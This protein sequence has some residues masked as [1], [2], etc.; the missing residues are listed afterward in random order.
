MTEFLPAGEQRQCGSESG[1]GRNRAGPGNPPIPRGEWSQPGFLQP[2]ERL[3]RGDPPLLVRM[4][5]ALLEIS[6]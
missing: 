1:S 3:P 2:G 6:N 5:S 4:F